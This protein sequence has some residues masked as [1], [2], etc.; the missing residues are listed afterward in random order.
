MVFPSRYV[1]KAPLVILL[2][3]L[4]LVLSLFIA[5]ITLPRGEVIGLEGGANFMDYW[6]KWR[7][8]DP[9]HMVV[10]SFGD[11]NC[12]QMEDR[13]II[14]NGNQMP[15]CAR[16]TAIFIGLLYGSLL[17]VRAR[18]FD[19]PI[20]T[21]VSVLPKRFRKG[22]FARF[23]FVTAAIAL[24]FLILPTALDGGIQLITNLYPNLFGFSY[25][26]TNPMRIITGLPAGVALGTVYCSLLMCLLSRREDGSDPLLPFFSGKRFNN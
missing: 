23:S 16:D 3:D 9:F 22:L 6:V 13:S 1:H 7:E 12:H 14:I 10:Y 2:L 25:Q 8:M 24:G 17:M 20:E 15:L 19:S 26:S 11:L 4:V 18:A 5:P 21:G